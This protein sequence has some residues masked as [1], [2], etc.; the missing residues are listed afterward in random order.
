MC[1]SMKHGKG[2][3]PSPFSLVRWLAMAG[4]CGAHSGRV[5]RGIAGHA[6]WAVAIKGA[7][8]ESCFDCRRSNLDGVDC[9]SS[10]SV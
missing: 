8:S 10:D 2:P 7:E 5:S 9:F 1:L 6:L 4:G 3:S